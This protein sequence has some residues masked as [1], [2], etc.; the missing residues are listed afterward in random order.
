MMATA[1]SLSPYSLTV[2]YPICVS[3]FQTITSTL[4]F[5]SEIERTFKFIVS[6]HRK[7]IVR[8]GPFMQFHVMA[9]D[10]HTCFYKNHTI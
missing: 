8:G 4:K 9:T 10:V 2:M 5:V 6:S 1:S 3:V 7:C